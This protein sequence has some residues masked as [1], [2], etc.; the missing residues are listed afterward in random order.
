MKCRIDQVIPDSSGLFATVEGAIELENLP[1]VTVD[2]FGDAH[3]DL[4]VK[5]AVKIRLVDVGL[6]NQKVLASGDSEKHADQN[7]L[8]N[9]CQSL[10]KIYPRASQEA[11]CNDPNLVPQDATALILFAT[12]H[13]TT[14][15]DLCVCRESITI[16]GV[17][18]LVLVTERGLV[19]VTER[20]EL[21]VLSRAPWLT[22]QV[23]HCFAVIPRIRQRKS[24]VVLH[25]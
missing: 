6:M 23:L 14:S 18:G 2:A 20:G 1:V 25:S 4:L 10:T 5:N 8:G 19:L 17:E 21:V 13:E 11:S 7:E 9:G 3:V 16:N 15:N 22:V 24:E 12:E